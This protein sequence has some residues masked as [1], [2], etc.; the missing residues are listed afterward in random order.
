MESLKVLRI[1]LAYFEAE[2]MGFLETAC[3]LAAAANFWRID[4]LTFMA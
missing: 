3:N 1:V 2:L 4:C